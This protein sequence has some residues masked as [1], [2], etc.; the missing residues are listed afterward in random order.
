MIV[1][2]TAT[3]IDKVKKAGM[4]VGIAIK[5]NTP[6]EWVIPYVKDIDMVLVMTVEPGFGC[7]SLIESCLSKVLKRLFLLIKFQLLNKL[8]N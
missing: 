6:V 3:I 2:K 4:K 8:I 5:P 1:D 7:Q